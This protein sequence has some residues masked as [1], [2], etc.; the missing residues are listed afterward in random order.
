MICN[1][2][3]SGWE[4]VYQPAH[5][6]LA[7]Q[8]IAPWKESA[9]PERWTELLAATAQHDNGWQ[10]WEPGQRLTLLGTP[11]HFEDTSVPD[12]VAQSERAV[13]R[14]WHQ[15]LWSGL[16][17][18]SHIEHLHRKRPEPEIKALLVHQAELRRGWRKRLG[19]RQ[20]DVQASYDFLL[21]GDT[22]SLIL[23]G[24]QLPFGG[25]RVEIEPIDGTR[26]F[27]WARDE[28]SL[29]VE[30]WPYALDRFEV[31]VDAY[32]LTRLTFTSETELAESLAASKPEVRRW[33]IRREH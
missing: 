28:G 26:Y 15:S 31:S 9:R 19:V 29:G 27:T 1:R 23:C 16:L 6:L 20:R 18:S 30:P 32:P 25:R 33:E 7:A 22:F 24:R 8:L 11:L 4:V 10:E 17:I 13:Q 5:A 12:L 3:E 2:T 21:W 14:A